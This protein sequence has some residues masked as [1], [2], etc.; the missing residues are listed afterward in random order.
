MPFQAVVG[1][2]F[3]GGLVIGQDQ[4]VG[5]LPPEFRGDRDG[6]IERGIRRP[7]IPLSP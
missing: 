4:D 6:R 2:R 3:G 5:L 1:E 7:A